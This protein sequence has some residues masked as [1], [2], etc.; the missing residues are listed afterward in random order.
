[1]LEGLT[2]ANSG[3]LPLHAVRPDE[4]AMFLDALPGAG[5]AF[6]RATGFAA[7][8][9]EHALLPGPDGLAGAVVG[10]GIESSPWSYGG[11]PKLLPA[12]SSWRL[13]T[14]SGDAGLAT[15]G[16]ALGAWA[17]HTVARWHAALRRREQGA[18]AG[19]EGVACVAGAAC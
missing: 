4:L 18:A 12:G 9:G 17:A 11:L 14:G 1:M 13:E 6:L 2:A 19:A 5:A 16:W 8:S 10:L 15:L 3:A 7:R